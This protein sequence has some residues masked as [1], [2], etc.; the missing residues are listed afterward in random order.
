[1]G[2]LTVSHPTDYDLQWPGQGA[3]MWDRVARAAGCLLQSLYILHLLHWILPAT[4]SHLPVL[5]A[6]YYQGETLPLP[7]LIQL[8]LLLSS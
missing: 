3:S 8:S 1:M 7:L 2:C 5:P 4:G 6:H